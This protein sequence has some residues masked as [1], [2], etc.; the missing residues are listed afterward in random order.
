MLIH[1]LGH[2][3]ERADITDEF[4]PPFFLLAGDVGCADDALV[5]IDEEEGEDLAVAGFFGVD[6]VE[7]LNAVLVNLQVWSEARLS[8]DMLGGKS[9]LFLGMRIPESRLTFGKV[10]SRPDCQAHVSHQLP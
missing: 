4:F 1:L 7:R 10:S 6:E 9:S 8:R 2:I 5:R 3:P